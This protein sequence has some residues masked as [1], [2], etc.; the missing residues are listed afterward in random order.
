M[1]PSKG[2]YVQLEHI[3][4]VFKAL[5]WKKLWKQKSNW[6][7]WEK[8][9]LKNRQIVQTP[10]F[11]STL[12]VFWK[13]SRLKPTQFFAPSTISLWPKSLL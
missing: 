11:H 1:N 6:R 5:K 8:I 7:T 9:H 12:K 3:C 13:K 10:I 4:T 2:K